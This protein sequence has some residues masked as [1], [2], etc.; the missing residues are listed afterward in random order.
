MNLD[1]EHLPSD[2][3]KCLERGGQKLHEMLWY[4]DIWF[5][6]LYLNSTHF[7]LRFLNFVGM[8]EIPF[9]KEAFKKNQHSFVFLLVT[10]K[11]RR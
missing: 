7:S 8:Y 5:F 10:S 2:H 6:N 11:Q 9:G 4:A 3:E 1:K